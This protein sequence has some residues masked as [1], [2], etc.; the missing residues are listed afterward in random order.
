MGWR[1]SAW[2]SSAVTS[3]SLGLREVHRWNQLVRCVCSMSDS[4][5]CR[6]DRLMEQKRT[7]LPWTGASGSAC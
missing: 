6:C 1:P 3:E 4:V 7:R 2:Q 5:A